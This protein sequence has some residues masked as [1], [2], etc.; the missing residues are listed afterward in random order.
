VSAIFKVMVDAAEEQRD[1]SGSGQEATAIEES[2]LR[3]AGS[4]PSKATLK[5]QLRINRNPVM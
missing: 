2:D 1:E 3:Q 5:Q 4:S